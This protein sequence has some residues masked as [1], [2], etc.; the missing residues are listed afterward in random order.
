MDDL[1]L[2]KQK[3]NIVD[4]ISEYI[5]LKKAGVNFKAPCPF[6]Q[7]KTP[8]FVVSP[9]RGIWH[10]F[11]CQKGGDIF[12]F[13]MEKDSLEFK[14]ALELLAQKAGVTLKKTNKKEV[15]VKEKLFAAHQKAQ[16]FYQYF[17]L[18][19][20]LGKK[21]LEYLKKRGLTEQTIKEFGI[22]YSPQNWDVLTNFMKKRDF[23]VAD[24]VDSGLAVPSRAGCYDRFRGRI[25]FPLIDVRGRIIGFSGRI[26]DKGEPA[27]NALSIA[28]AGGPKYINSPQT[29]IFDKKRFLF[30]I[31]L[32]KGD[33]KQKN[34]AIIC[35]GEMD[36]IMS[37]QS[38]IKNIVASKGTALTEEHIEMLKKYTDTLSLCFD[39]DLA[40]DAASR[41]G[42]QMADR[43]GY[44]LKIVTVEGGKDPADACLKDPEVWKKAVE[45]ATPIYDYYLNSV[46]KRFNIKEATAK[47]NI[48]AELLPVWKKINDP[49]TKEHYIQKLSAML[50]VKDDFIREEI[51]NYTDS[52]GEKPTFKEE[53]GRPQAVKIEAVAK[54]RQMLLEEYLIAL[55]L[56]IPPEH[57][58][59][60][61]FPETLFTTEELKQVYVLLVIFLD[62]IS[63]KGKSFKITE[64]VKT[65]PPDL[66]PIVDRL[67]LVQI[68]DKLETAANFQ[69]EVETVVAEL[70]KMLIKSSL[71]KLSLKIKS[72]QEFENVETLEV[73]TRR[74]R[75]LS[76]KLK[77]FN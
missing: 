25:M 40:G 27:R 44:N 17:L 69:K 73:L 36:M 39:M 9:E 13:V 14:D 37:Y 53:T 52:L 8:S 28:D 6:H 15:D 50:Q 32:A 33:I 10:C 30:G 24:L 22:G 11:G 66:I 56:K 61:S 47:K 74:F 18:E 3:I 31:H 70:K 21:A 34:E 51:D 26:L 48:L 67:Y 23:S 4:L 57:T 29:T 71:E 1:D 38:G 68:D 59:V 76:L 64:F 65:L 58:F 46:S 45:E 2:I 7:E 35:E 12:K 62:S 20:P 16:Q 60:P 72:A 75:D 42:I 19:H 41:R 63:F 55:M 43:A 77:S 5:P 49:I 54:N